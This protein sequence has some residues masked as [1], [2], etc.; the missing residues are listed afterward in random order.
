MLEK[1]FPPIRKRFSDLNDAEFHL[2]KKWLIL[3]QTHPISLDFSQEFKLEQIDNIR[4]SSI[5]LH[6]I[7][8]DHD[9]NLTTATF[10]KNQKLEFRAYVLIE[11]IITFATIFNPYIL[12]YSLCAVL[13][14]FI[15]YLFLFNDIYINRPMFRYIKKKKT[16]KALKIAKNNTK[17]KTK[18]QCYCLCKKIPR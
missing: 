7:R 1:L 6:R 9:K 14:V 15:L 5:R 11:V 12:P 16:V 2:L 13:G 3:S 18:A 17:Q 4:D 10:S 8:Y